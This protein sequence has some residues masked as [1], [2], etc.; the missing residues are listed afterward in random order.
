MRKAYIGVAVV[1]ALVLF[2]GS[3]SAVTVYLAKV[4]GA[5]GTLGP[6]TAMPGEVITI[7]IYV[8]DIVKLAGFQM[9]LESTGPVSFLSRP[10]DEATEERPD[11]MPDHLGTW[12][13]TG[14]EWIDMPAAAD[15][16]TGMLLTGSI[17]GGGDIA[18]F[19]LRADDLGQIVIDVASKDY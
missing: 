18:T 10:V 2:C 11:P 1:L 13:K 5:M 6:I 3:A 16:C 17:S 8:A 9:T 4:D 12:F 19:D 15:Y 14:N 7:G